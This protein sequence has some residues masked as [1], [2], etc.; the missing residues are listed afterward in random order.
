MI[1][2]IQDIYRFCCCE[3]NNGHAYFGDGRIEQERMK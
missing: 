1:K 2:S 3:K